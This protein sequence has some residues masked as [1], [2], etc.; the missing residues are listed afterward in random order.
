M[1]TDDM[2]VYHLKL[3]MQCSSVYHDHLAESY[4]AAY[5]CVSSCQ[6]CPVALNVCL[7]HLAVSCR[8][9]CVLVS[10]SSV[11]TVAHVRVAW[12]SLLSLC[13]C[14]C[15]ISVYPPERC[16]FEV[17]VCPFVLCMKVYHFLVSHFSTC[18]SANCLHERT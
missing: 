8:S 11:L 10:S 4:C 5:A 15:T 13:I 7:C 12:H 16:A 17:V 3:A 6:L 1:K 2:Y 9:A 14:M 18:A